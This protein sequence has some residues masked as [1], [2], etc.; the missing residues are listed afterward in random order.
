MVP[1]ENGVMGSVV[2]EEGP[3]CRASAAPPWR[4]SRCGSRSHRA[5][6]STR[7]CHR[8]APDEKHNGRIPAVSNR[9]DSSLRARARRAGALLVE[10]PGDQKRRALRNLTGA[11][12]DSSHC[13]SE[14]SHALSLGEVSNSPP[15]FGNKWPLW[16]GRLREHRTFKKNWVNIVQT[17]WTGSALNR[18]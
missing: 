14:E 16:S 3:E 17:I 9:C 15:P 2:T 4:L 13:R 18:L 10:P 6:I 8:S 7:L 1:F 11:L 5:K 12:F